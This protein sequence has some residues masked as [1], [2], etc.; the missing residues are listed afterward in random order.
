MQCDICGKTTRV[1]LT[2]ME[3]AKIY[4]CSLCNPSGQGKIIRPR[5]DKPNFI[6]RD[7]V[8]KF[9]MRKQEPFD[10][11]NYDLVE[12][13]AEQIKNLREAQK[14][15]YD[16]FSKDLYVTASYLQKI[17]NDKLKPSAGMLL[18]LYERYGLLLVSK[19][20]GKDVP[21]I[22]KRKF[23]F[24]PRPH[25]EKRKFDNKNINKSDRPR[26]R[27]NFA[28]EKDNFRGSKEIYTSANSEE[29]K[30]EPVAQNAKKKIIL[31]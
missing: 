22:P 23:E 1:F 14:K 25:F 7:Y 2:E 16:E 8:P 19:I 30:F 31:A 10:L 5:N 9:K 29:Q 26:S 27:D 20:P 3:G 6:K 18:K 13:Y 12:N 4:V 11:S 28:G 17:E 21:E 15:T 24:K